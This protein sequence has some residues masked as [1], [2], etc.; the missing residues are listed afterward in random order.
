MKQSYVRP[1]SITLAREGDLFGFLS[2]ADWDIVSDGGSVPVVA[3]SPS[4][5]AHDAWIDVDGLS[6]EDG[7]VVPVHGWSVERY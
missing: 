5:V 1:S 6:I 7:Y 4:G 3:T 2:D